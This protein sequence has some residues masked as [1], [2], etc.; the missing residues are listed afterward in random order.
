MSKRVLVV[1]RDLFFRSKLGAVIQA[2]GGEAARDDGA[3][4]LAVI[5]LG[6]AEAEGRIRTW[7]GQGIP[8]LAFGSHVTPEA[9]RA[10][11]AA[12]AVAVP[13]SQVEAQLRAMLAA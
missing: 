8:V 9:L 4:D 12:G 10:A 6:S 11:R 13:N 1:T 2:T 3:C 5:E 7:I